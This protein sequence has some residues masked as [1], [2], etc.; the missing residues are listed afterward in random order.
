MGVYGCAEITDLK[1][2]AN[3]TGFENDEYRTNIRGKQEFSLRFPEPLPFEK[4]F[5]KKKRM[6]RG[7]FNY[8]EDDE[9]LQI[10]YRAIKQCKK[11]PDWQRELS[12]LKNIYEYYNH[13]NYNITYDE[14]QLDQYN[15]ESTLVKKLADPDS[16]IIKQLNEISNEAYDEPKKISVIQYPRKPELSASL[17]FKNNHICQVCENPTFQTKGGLYY[18]ESHHIL[19]RSKGGRDI[20]ENI[21]IVCANCH[22]K[23]HKGDDTVQIEAYRILKRKKI[24]LNFDILKTNNQISNDVY[25]A[26]QKE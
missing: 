13:T 21:V 12:V 2:Y 20:A 3:Y 23:F 19:P 6:S 15:E 11:N 22:N 8:L 16:E 24:F 18:T 14:L 5:M 10:I 17:K 4:K 7:G 9:D 26:V 25:D 1:K